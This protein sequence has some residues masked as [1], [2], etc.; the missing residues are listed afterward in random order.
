MK[1]RPVLG[2]LTVLA[3]IPQILFIAMFILIYN[4][5]I[6]HWMIWEKITVGLCCMIGGILLWQGKIW[7]YYISAIGWGLLLFISIGGLFAFISSAS[8]PY[9][10]YFN[11]LLGF[12]IFVFLIRDVFKARKNNQIT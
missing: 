4:P 12:P 7:G 10:Y 2:T 9:Y 8:Q 3:A 11:L 6:T 5:P 1:K